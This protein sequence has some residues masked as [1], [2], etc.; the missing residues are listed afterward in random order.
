MLHVVIVPE[1]MQVN[2]IACEKIV[3]I[4]SKNLLPAEIQITVAQ[5]FNSFWKSSDPMLRCFVIL[6]FI[7]LPSSLGKKRLTSHFTLQ[8]RSSDDGSSI[9]ETDITETTETTLVETNQDELQVIFKLS[10]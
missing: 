9:A 1:V 6:N 7:Y 4:I 3:F 2:M 10:L 5:T 8:I